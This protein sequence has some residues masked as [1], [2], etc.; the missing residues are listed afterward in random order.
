MVERDAAWFFKL[1]LLCPNL[2]LL[3]TFGP[4]NTLVSPAHVLDA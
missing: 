3:L 1:L 4:M 2:Q